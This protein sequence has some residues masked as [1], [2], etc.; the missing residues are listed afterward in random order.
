MAEQDPWKKRGEALRS[1]SRALAIPSL[2]LGGPLGCGLVGYLI[3]RYFEKPQEGL[4]IG[5]FLGL[6]AAIYE[7]VRILRQMAREAK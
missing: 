6:A 1:G 2:L 7:V 4:L 3:G 5:G